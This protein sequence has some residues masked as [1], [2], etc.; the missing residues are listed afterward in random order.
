MA[1]GQYKYVLTVENSQALRKL[2][3]MAKVAERTKGKVEKQTTAQKQK[4]RELG[5]QLLD[6]KRQYQ[7]AQ[8]AAS[9]F[10]RHGYNRK[11]HDDLRKL[12]EQIGRVRDE[13]GKARRELVNFNNEQLKLRRGGTQYSAPIGPVGPTRGFRGN[14]GRRA[15]VGGALS[16]G[17]G[18]MGAAGLAGSAL[19]G[20]IAGIAAALAGGVLQKLEDF[21]RAVGQYA[22]DAAVAAAETTRMRRALAGVLGAEAPE[23]FE[24]IKRVVSDFNV[25]LQEATTQFT[26]FVSSAKASG[27]GAED[28]EKSFRGLIA[29]NKAL[30]GSQEQANG[31]LL[32]A[33]QIFGKGKT[34]AEELRGQ[35]GERLPGAVAMFA[36]SMGL[37]TAELDKRLEEGTVSV[38]DFVKFTGD[39]LNQFEG[40]AK[41]ISKGPEE[42]GKRLEVALDL[43]KRNIGA[44]LAP[45]GAAFQTTFALIVNAINAGIEAMNR[46]LGLTPESAVDK[47][48]QALE[49]RQRDLTNAI[50]GQGK[51]VDLGRQG[52]SRRQ[53]ESEARAAL[54]EAQK[55][56]DSARALLGK[57]TGSIEKGDLVTAQD[58]IDNRK[59]SGQDPAKIAERVDRINAQNARRLREENAKQALALLKQRYDIEDR[60]E[61]EKQALV[62]LGLRGAARAQQETFNA[63]L[64]QNTAIDQQIRRLDDAVSAAEERVAAAQEQL[65]AAQT[66]PDRARAQ[67]RVDIE[68]ARLAGASARRDQFGRNALEMRSNTFEQMINNSTAAF[69]ERAA[70]LRE[71]TENLKLRNRLMMEGFSPEMVESQMQQAQI[72]K[73]RLAQLEI[74][75]TAFEQGLINAEQYALILDSINESATAAK[76]AVEGLTEAQIAA[77]DPV[78]NYIKTAQDYIN[79]TK[80]RV[81]EMLNTVDQ[82]LA[83]SINGILTGTMTAQEAFHSF[84]KSVGQAFLKMAAQMIAKLIII[85]LLKTAIGLFG[86]GGGEA[87]EPAVQTDSFAGVPNDVLDSVLQPAPFA[88]GGIVT[89][90]TNALI[91][92]GGMNEAVVPLPNGKAIPVDMKGVG[93][94]GNVTSNVTVN[95]SN[96]GG[97]GSDVSGEDA[98]KLGKAIDNAIRKVIMDERR[99]GGLLYGGR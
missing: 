14:T 76:E 7:D 91:G 74:Y 82:A 4:T 96:E 21:S 97:G 94:A 55:N 46:F 54:E 60:L 36:K 64:N 19:T 73:D 57:G 6:L 30:G 92:E 80:E 32:A 13:Y 48:Q 8:N 87:A 15:A 99:S 90:P 45:I 40:D 2:A 16:K 39:L 22:N 50:K 11:Q 65:A 28:I 69:R 75:N 71:E 81:S 56:L 26:R 37:T 52:S 59:G 27:V 18:G 98:G 24:A 31:I 67:G 63:Y 42:A 25:P 49:A 89:Q 44:L 33:T 83:A 17:A 84:F 58:L 66:A 34:S 86:G 10:G 5:K 29:A 62:L 79:N 38:A 51:L 1:Q 20:G 95:V 70:A 85:K 3:E 88:K 77:A 78:K 9:N 72:D 23:A 35:I 68:T 93:A 43:L 41:A 53:T 12:K 47:A 61:K